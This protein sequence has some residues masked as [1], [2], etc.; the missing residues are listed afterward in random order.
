M[1]FVFRNL[2][3]VHDYIVLFHVCICEHLNRCN[4]CY[5]NYIGII[6]TLFELNDLFVSLSKIE[7][8]GYL[9]LKKS[10]K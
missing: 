8:T 1:S 5:M 6:F 9:T 7:C 2:S 10:V 3:F 4:S